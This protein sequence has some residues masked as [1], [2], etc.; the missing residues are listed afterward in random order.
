MADFLFYTAG[1]ILIIA[2]ILQIKKIYNLKRADDLSFFAVLGIVAGVSLNEVAVGLN[3]GPLSFFLANSGAL[4]SW[5]VVLFQKIY[6]SQK[7]S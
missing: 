6:Y 7:R 4:I 3:G 2:P 1:I 5:C